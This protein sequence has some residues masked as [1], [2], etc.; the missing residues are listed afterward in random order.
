MRFIELGNDAYAALEIARAGVSQRQPPRG[1]DQKLR[2]QQLLQLSDPFGVDR[3]G[4]AQPAGRSNEA[5]AFDH[6]NE[7]ADA[8][9]FVHD[10]CSRFENYPFPNRSIIIFLT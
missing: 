8:G 3:F 6:A 7:H 4:Q 10:D 5:A 1:A 2:L 9:Q